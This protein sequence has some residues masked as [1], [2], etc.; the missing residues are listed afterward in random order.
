MRSSF[1]A[2]LNYDGLSGP[3]VACLQ[4]EPSELQSPDH[5][6]Q[7]LVRGLGIAAKEGSRRPSLNSLR[8]GFAVAYILV[9]GTNK[10]LMSGRVCQ[11]FP[12]TF[13]IFRQRIPSGI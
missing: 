11:S 7:K 1:A 4:A 6:F 13:V 2:D 9:S 12:S 5:T 8:H 3:F 10:A